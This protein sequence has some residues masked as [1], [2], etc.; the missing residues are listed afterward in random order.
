MDQ[1]ID[2]PQHP[3]SRTNQN[4]AVDRIVRKKE[5]FSITGLSDTTIW[6][7]ERATPSQFPKRLWIGK[8][9]CGW[10]ES[11]ILGWLADR[12]AE[13]TVVACL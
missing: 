5:V 11:E 8:N 1:I 2:N 12:A 13:R 7:K 10:L 4:K 9:S 6:R 3:T